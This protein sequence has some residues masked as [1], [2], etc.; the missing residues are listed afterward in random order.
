M[1][2]GLVSLVCIISLPFCRTLGGILTL[3]YC[4]ELLLEDLMHRAIWKDPYL[5]LQVK[6]Q[7]EDSQV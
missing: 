3:F 7:E 1:L 6:I 2:A 4:M 5:E